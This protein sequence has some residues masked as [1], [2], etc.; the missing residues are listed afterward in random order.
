MTP[1]MH[2]IRDARLS[3]KQSQEELQDNHIDNQ[4]TRSQLTH[5]RKLSNVHQLY[6]IWES[7]HTHTLFI[8]PFFFFFF[9]I[10]EEILLTRIEGYYKKHGWQE[11]LNTKSRDRLFI[12]HLTIAYAMMDTLCLN[13]NSINFAIVPC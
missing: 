11:I 12:F 7:D 5:I 3:Q 9:R 2:H 13:L 8:F 6:N 1:F 4:H 10:K